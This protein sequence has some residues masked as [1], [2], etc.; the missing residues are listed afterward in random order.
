VTR[1][2][3]LLGGCLATGFAALTMFFWGLERTALIDAA[4]RA[5]GESMPLPTHLY[6]L[7]FVGI[8]LLAIAMWGAVT[9]WG[10]FLKANPETRQIPVW[11]L[12]VLMAA[13]GGAAFLGLA[14]HSGYIGSLAVVPMA[15][16]QGYIAYQVMAASF[17]LAS[18]VALGTRW[19]P[20]Y[21]PHVLD[22]LAHTTTTDETE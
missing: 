11:V 9:T 20:G 13:G 8:V 7:V 1:T 14:V 15:V 10:G 6:V 19:A 22:A 16:N 5:R 21:R 17:V 4:V 18:S 2:L 3:W 12:V